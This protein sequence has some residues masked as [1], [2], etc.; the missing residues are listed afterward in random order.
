MNA[1]R[2]KISVFVFSLLLLVMAGCKFNVDT[3]SVLGL[4]TNLQKIL[5]R[6]VDFSCDADDAA[7]T[8]KRIAGKVKDFDSALPIK[9]ARLSIT[10]LTDISPELT[11]DTGD[12]KLSGIDPSVKK[13][14]LNISATGYE[15]ESKERDM[16]LCQNHKA[17]VTLTKVSLATSGVDAFMLDSSQLDKGRIQ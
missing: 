4:L 7:T 1:F 6:G 10:E 14:T 13:I 17:N 11:T 8:A 2:I 16:T 5:P 15:S 3:P 9:D 12:Y